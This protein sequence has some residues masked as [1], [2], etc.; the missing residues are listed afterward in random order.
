MYQSELITRSKKIETSLTEQ[1]L[2]IVW[3]LIGL[4]PG[5]PP[6]VFSFL[7]SKLKLNAFV[8]IFGEEEEKHFSASETPPVMYS[9]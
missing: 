2:P 7:K 3:D 4:G 9:V 5:F 6:Q 8:R 1:S